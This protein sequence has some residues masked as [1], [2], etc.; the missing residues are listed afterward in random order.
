M[1][2]SW[3]LEDASC[4]QMRF[5]EVKRVVKLT[6]DDNDIVREIDGYEFA[7]FEYINRLMICEEEWV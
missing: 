4:D 7:G 2:L 3:S 5:G 6:P 1:K